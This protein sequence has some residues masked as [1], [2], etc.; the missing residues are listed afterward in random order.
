MTKLETVDGNAS[1]TTQTLK[2]MLNDLGDVVIDI[3]KRSANAGGYSAMPWEQAV[4]IVSIGLNYHL[5][6]QQLKN[7]RSPE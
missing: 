1:G 3:R 2:E 7:A 6:K 5:T 4:N